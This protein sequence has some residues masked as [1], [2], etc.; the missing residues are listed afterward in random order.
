MTN[1]IGPC[2][3]AVLHCTRARKEG[4]IP[5]AARIESVAAAACA[6]LCVCGCI[7]CKMR[8][9][10]CGGIADSYVVGSESQFLAPK[11]APPPLKGA[12]LLN[13]FAI[14]QGFA[15]AKR[16]NNGASSAAKCH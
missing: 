13:L 5:P 12:C 4:T 1:E 14:G 8:L 10:V 3:G 2:P 16:A 15:A 9:G 6:C 7:T 11:S